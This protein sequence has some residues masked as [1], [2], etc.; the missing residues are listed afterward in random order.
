M[1]Y[2]VGD[3]VRIKSREWYEAN[4]NKYGDVDFPCC[5]FTAAMSAMCGKVYEITSVDTDGTYKANDYW[6]LEE[7][8]EGLASE[9]KPLISTDLIKDIAEV[10]KKHNLGVSI[11]E[12]EGKLIVEPLKVEEEE[13]LPIDT[14][15][16]VADRLDD[17]RFRYYAGKERC[18]I[19]S[20]KSEETCDTNAWEYIIPFDK[21]NPL[22][23][24]QS[25]QYNIVKK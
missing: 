11:S 1:L 15:C 22:D 3:K 7:Y 4:K 5:A 19:Y 17:W 18:F 16:M 10:I 13:D 9:E 6:L 21:F 12:N 20:Y 23:I 25:L 14:P 8:I 24:E 2:K